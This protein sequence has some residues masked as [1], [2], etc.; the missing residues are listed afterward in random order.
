MIRLEISGETAKEFGEQLSA[1]AQLMAGGAATLPMSTA[2]TAPLKEEPKKTK[3]KVE[4]PAKQVTGEVVQDE[5]PADP[6]GGAGTADSD[7]SSAATGASPA[8]REDV[9]KR[10]VEY[11][12]PANGGPQGLRELLSEAGAA[13]GKWSEI[14]DEMLPALSARLDELLK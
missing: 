4:T 1:V 6:T 13:N 7:A 14:T 8:T 12:K 10:C 3:T 11:G 2:T 9:Q 5:K